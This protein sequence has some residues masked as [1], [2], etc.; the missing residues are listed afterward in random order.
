MFAQNAAFDSRVRGGGTAITTID[1]YRGGVLVARDIPWVKPSTVTVDE[2][3]SAWRTC[4]ITVADVPKNLVPK[5][6]QAAL[7]PY[8][9]DL[10]IRTGF[11]LTDGT[12]EQVPMG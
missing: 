5:T 1:A 6:P 8:G 12:V 3:A 9:T 2:G 10:F 11:R 7:S 4:E